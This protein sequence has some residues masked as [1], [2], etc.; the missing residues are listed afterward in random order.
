[1]AGELA[2]EYAKDK[3]SDWINRE[4]V[5]FVSSMLVFGVM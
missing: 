1:M 5:P 3:T 4:N 2:A